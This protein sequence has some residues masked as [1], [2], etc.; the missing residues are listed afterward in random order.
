MLSRGVGYL[1]LNGFSGAPKAGE[2]AAAAMNF[3]AGSK[4]LIID[5]RENGGGSPDM[6]Q[7]LSTY[8]FDGDLVHLNSFYYRPSDETTQRWTL[9]YVPGDR[10][11]NSDVYILTSGN[12]FS[13][14]EEFTYNLKNLKRA[15]IIGE[16]TGGGAHP[17]GMMPASEYFAVFVPSGRAINPITNTNWEGV[18]VAPDIDIPAS[19]A[20]DKAH[21]LA[22][23]KLSQDYKGT[24][25]P[26][27]WTAARLDA[28]AHPCKTEDLDFGELIGNYGPRT[29]EESSGVLTYQRDKGPK[30]NL[31]CMAND[32]FMIKEIPYFR[33]KFIREKGQ[34]VAVEGIYENGH[35][36]FN[37]KTTSP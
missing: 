23:S 9:P 11:A 32:L 24:E 21:Y 29:I 7:I 17:G 8:L 37:R 5:L 15:K 19:E 14:A 28:M 25:N 36:D 22:V 34:V 6:I 30:Y 13:A 33:L 35:R 12:T 16:T 27:A 26:Y 20:L 4:A 18:G 1:K 10:L 3:L 2:T 31:T